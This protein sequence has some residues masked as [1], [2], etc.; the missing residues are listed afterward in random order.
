MGQ[1]SSVVEMGGACLNG[2]RWR[3]S[4]YLAKCGGGRWRNVLNNFLIAKKSRRVLQNAV[5]AGFNFGFMTNPKIAKPR[6]LV[7]ADG[8]AVTSPY[9][10]AVIFRVKE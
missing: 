6:L 1:R 7:V 4:R 9:F 3:G 5:F 2:G 8:R 10:C